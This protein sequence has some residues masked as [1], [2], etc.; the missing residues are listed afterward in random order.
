MW[1]EH[2]TTGRGDSFAAA[3]TCGWEGPWRHTHGSERTKGGLVRMLD[4]TYDRHLVAVAP[5]RPRRDR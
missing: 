4:D 5:A 2:W 3:C 1:D